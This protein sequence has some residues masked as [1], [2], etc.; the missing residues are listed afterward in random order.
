[1]SI[2]AEVAAQGMVVEIRNLHIA[3][4]GG[5]S[6]DFQSIRCPREGRS[7]TLEECMG[8]SE[9]ADVV[10]SAGGRG[11]FVSCR[12]AYGGAL[13]VSGA[14]GSA[15]AAE[16]T[17]VFAVMTSR[18]IAVRPDV[19]LEALADLLLE[20]NIGG[21]PVVDEEGRPLGIISKT[22]LIREHQANGDTGVALAPGHQLGRGHYRVE[23]GRGFHAESLPHATVA[24]A[25]TRSAFTV[26]ESAPVSQA[27]ALMA[28]EGVH[29]IPVVDDAGRVSGVIT[30]LDVLRWLAQ[31]EGYLAP[32][33]AGPAR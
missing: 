1:M 14:A 16:R 30:T 9:H 33:R 7:L 19:S 31:Q 21:A 27:A 11:A 12:A 22:D 25:M 15:S 24:D 2:L 13:E 4:G 6:A 18:V 32:P 10:R 8:C 29:R 17:P 20:R 5:A 28:F 23:A 3:S 26:S